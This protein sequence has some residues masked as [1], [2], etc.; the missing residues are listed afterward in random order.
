MEKEYWRDIPG[1][2][3]KYQICI[4]GEECRCRS[5]NYNRT[6]KV[7]MLSNNPG[8][9]D[10][11]ITW[12]LCKNGKQKAFPA[13]KWIAFTFPELVEN[14]YFEGAEIDHKDTNRLNN[15]PSNLRWV[16]HQEN[17][18]N[19]LTLKHNAE[20]R[21]GE[22]CWFYGQRHTEETKKKMSLARKKY[23]LEKKLFV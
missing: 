9:R 2:E 11:R 3:G 7:K 23:W 6:G 20:C 14:E 16:T 21:S 22:K 4:E 8:K 19:P 1:Y 13:A 15:H 17:C 18:N 12:N 5:L 10:G